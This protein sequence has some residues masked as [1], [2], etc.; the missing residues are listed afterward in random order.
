[1][2]AAIGIR[3]R[4][5]RP[6]VSIA[7]AL[8]AAGQGRRMQS[9]Q[10]KVLH[11]IAGAPLYFHALQSTGGLEVALTVAVT[12]HGEEAF[13]AS[14]AE[15]H[16]T[17][18][19]AYQD[20]Q[21]GTGD[22]LRTALAALE[23]F[24]G[25]V[26]VLYGDTPLMRPA[27]LQA[28]MTGLAD[29]SDLV[30]VGF[31]AENPT[32]YGRLITADGQLQEIVEDADTDSVTREIT[33]C[34]S[35]ILCGDRELLTNLLGAVGN[36]NAAGEYYLTDI[37]GIATA[38]GHRN[39]V[40]TC[41]EDEAMGI[42][43][44]AE[45]ARAESIMQDRLRARALEA[46]VTLVDPATVYFSHDTALAP[47][48][49]VEPHVIFGRKVSVASGATIRS[50]TRLDSCTIG[51]GAEVGPHAHIR[52]GSDIGAG[53]R[54]GNFVE[55]KASRMAAGAKAN[56]LSYIGDSDIGKNV[57]IGAGSVT[58]NYDG[59]AKH[60][61]RIGEKVFIG[62]GSMLVAPVEIG[63]GAMTAAGSVITEDVPAHSR[64]FGRARQTNKP[65]AGPKGV[66]AARHKEET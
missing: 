36:S 25:P 12:G 60:R 55:V 3:I 6:R 20:R 4:G 65:G 57:N 17:I 35:G 45:L 61:T 62:S 18:T 39:S 2:A 49:L 26:L 37:L 1:M 30:V 32:G 33:L 7:V 10:P 29:G 19:T 43:T 5:D 28:M 58:C 9:H 50:F 41:A 21:R 31:E 51:T 38:R 22:A 59:K 47:D 13:R 8:L 40:I 27:T 23:N 16:P 24:A 53:V 11:E 15:W 42:N 54:V 44:R 66:Q 46:G 14:C 63:E 52:P 64:A 56:H 34:N 48:V